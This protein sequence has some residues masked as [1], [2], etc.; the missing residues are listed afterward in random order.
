M[1]EADAAHPSPGVTLNRISRST[2]AFAVYAI[3]IAAAA[4]SIVAMT[5][6]FERD[7]FPARFFLDYGRYSVFPYPYTI[8]NFMYIVMALALA[9]LWLRWRAAEHEHRL[10][11]AHLLPEDDKSVLE[12][13]DL[14]LGAIRRRASTLFDESSGYLPYLIDVTI[15]RLL[16]SKSIDQVLAVFNSSIDIISH[17]IDLNYQMIRYLIWLIPTIGFIGTVV[18]ITVAL[19]VI[20]PIKLDLKL[21][22]DRLGIAFY[23]T[24]IALVESMIIF[25]FQNLVQRRE[26]AALNMSASYC[27]KNL[28][29]RMYV[30][31]PTARPS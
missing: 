5:E 8:Q 27:L 31:E 1:T 3:A 14:R 15:S 2:N 7:S 21:V 11:A 6:L 9:G 28:I 26:E 10:L 17:R 19:E 13:A 30:A 23:T 24:I 22:T 29:N 18:G 12:Y 20:D 4:G 16:S 25:F